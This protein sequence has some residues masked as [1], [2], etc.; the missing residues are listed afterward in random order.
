MN[1]PTTQSPPTPQRLRVS[2]LR[3]SRDGSRLVTISTKSVE[4]PPDHRLVAIQLI[5]RPWRL[6]VKLTSERI[7]HARKAS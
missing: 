2:L 5:Q 1:N 4:L 3:P 6:T 7:A